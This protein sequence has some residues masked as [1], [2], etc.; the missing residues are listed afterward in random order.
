MPESPKEQILLRMNTEIAALLK[1]RA[2]S[3]DK[4]FTGYILSLGMKDLASCGMYPKIKL[5]HTLDNDIMEMSKG[6]N[7]PSE[8]DFNNDER[9]EQIWKR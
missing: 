5:P 7:A 2:R 1:T 4:S 6:G 9:L 8:A 3:L